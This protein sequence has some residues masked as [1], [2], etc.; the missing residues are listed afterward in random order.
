[1]AVLKRAI[2]K[3]GRSL[4]KWLSDWPLENQ[5]SVNSHHHHEERREQKQTEL[6]RIEKREKTRDN[7]TMK[8]NKNDTMYIASI[9]TR[10]LLC[11]DLLEG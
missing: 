5:N 7:I 9:D 6:L 8:K 3:T 2:V 11:S 1:L 10:H 4:T